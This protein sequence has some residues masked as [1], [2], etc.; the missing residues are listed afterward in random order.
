MT[1][2][3]QQ[4]S[5]SNSN[6]LIPVPDWNKF[7]SWPPQGGLRHLIFNEKTNGFSSA[8]KRVGRRVLIDEAEFFACVDRQNGG[9]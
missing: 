1:T 9:V 4:V 8:F 6:R 2:T 3:A 7:H 5:T